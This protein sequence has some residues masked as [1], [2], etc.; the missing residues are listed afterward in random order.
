MNAYFLKRGLSEKSFAKLEAG[1]NAFPIP[2]SVAGKQLQLRFAFFAIHNI[3]D[4]LL[5]RNHRGKLRKNHSSH[6][7]QVALPLQHSAE[8]G[9]VRLQPVLFVVPICRISQIPAHP[10]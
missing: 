8:L 7:E 2:I 3:E 1:V 6:R 10:L 5:S 4:S 9:P